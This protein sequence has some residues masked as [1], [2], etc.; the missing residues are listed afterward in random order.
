VDDAALVRFF[1][2]VGNLLRDGDRFVD[3]ERPAPQAVGEV[4]AL[5]ELEDQ[6]DDWAGRGMPRPCAFV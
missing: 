4:F 3:G 6:R 2:A 1:E 5:H